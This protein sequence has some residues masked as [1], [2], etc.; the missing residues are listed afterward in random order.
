ML[1]RSSECYVVKTLDKPEE[2]LVWKSMAWD[3]AFSLGLVQDRHLFS[4]LSL[5]DSVQ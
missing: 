1:R 2:A 5:T 4:S 3:A